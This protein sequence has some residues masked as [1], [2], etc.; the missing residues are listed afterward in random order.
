VN[1]LTLKAAAAS[2][3]AVAAA[4]HRLLLLLLL[5]LIPALLH[6]QCML[7][8]T[9]TSGLQFTPLQK[10]LQQ[11]CIASTADG[12]RQAPHMT[13]SAT[14]SEEGLKNC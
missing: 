6:S 1:S 2:A 5:L 8:A 7:E 9:D 10:L 3:A 12:S 14:D 4:V 13:L 11:Q